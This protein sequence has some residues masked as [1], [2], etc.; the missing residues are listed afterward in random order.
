VV[1][2]APKV[3]PHAPLRQHY[4][5]DAERPRYVNALFDEAAPHYEWINRML[6][7]GS[8]EAYRRLALQRSGLRPD[9]RLLDIATGTGLVLRP[10]AD[11]TGDQGLVVG[12][13]P[14]ASMLRQSRVI[15]PLPLVQSRGEALPFA[16]AVFD[17]VSLG[18]GLRHLAD[19]D[20]LFRE[21]FRV[22]RPGG[23]LLVLEFSRPRSGPG[24][25]LARLCLKT[26]APLVTRLGT[27]SPGAEKVMRYC[28]DTVDQLV[29]RETVLASEGR[30]GFEEVS[31]QEVFGVFVEYRARKPEGV[32]VKELAL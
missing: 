23:R 9:M 18:Y 1:E 32:R 28:W 5:T 29:P 31:G 24:G 2:E 13:D 17:F 14:S 6:S 8:G 10:A 30:A 7:L 26:L 11:I 15:R 22:L 19:L 3:A 20:V 4:G 25:A 27:R 16:T 12:L 21:C